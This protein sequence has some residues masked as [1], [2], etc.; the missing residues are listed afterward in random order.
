MSYLIRRTPEFI[1]DGKYAYWEYK[2]TVD[3]YARLW[4]DGVLIASV[5]IGGMYPEE[6]IKAALAQEVALYEARHRRNRAE[7]EA[8]R[9]VFSEEA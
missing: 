8:Y 6:R 1:V 9:A 4:R 3:G 5:G 7:V 2:P